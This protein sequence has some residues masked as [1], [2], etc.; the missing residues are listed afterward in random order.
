V[1]CFVKLLLFENSKG[2]GHKNILNWHLIP[3]IVDKRGFEYNIGIE[4]KM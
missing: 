2:S 4:I 1:G 3:S